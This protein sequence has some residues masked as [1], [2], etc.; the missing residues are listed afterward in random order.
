MVV[1]FDIETTGLENPGITC[2]ATCVDGEVMTWCSGNPMDK[3][4]A[5]RMTPEDCCNLATYLM[6]YMISGA[7]LVTWNGLKFDFRI[8][9]EQCRNDWMYGEIGAMA[10]DHYDIGFQMVCELGY[11]AGLDAVAKGMGFQGKAE[12]M[13]GAKAPEMWAADR[14]SQELVLTYVGQDVITTYEVALA[15]MEGRAVKWISKK[16]RPMSWKPNLP[17]MTVM[18][19]N[20]L[21]EPKMGWGTP[22]PREEFY[23]WI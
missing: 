8:L 2:A 7:T 19:A 23:N 4:L 11:M 17:L 22:W 20:S 6:S 18:E 12:G 3:L 21:P 16:S 10:L 1:T 13:S 14:K 15:I 9:A 5:P